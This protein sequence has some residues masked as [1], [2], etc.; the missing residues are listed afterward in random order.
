MGVAVGGWGAGG[1]AAVHVGDTGGA[2]PAPGKESMS[3]ENRSQ[4]PASQDWPSLRDHIADALWHRSRLDKSE[5]QAKVDACIR[6]LLGIPAAPPGAL[7]GVEGETERI[8]AESAFAAWV[9]R[10]KTAEAQVE[11]LEA[12]NRVPMPA[13]PNH[14]YWL[15]WAVRQMMVAC[16]GR[17]ADFKSVTEAAVGVGALVAKY[18]AHI[19]GPMGVK[20][21]EGAPTKKGGES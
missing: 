17:D 15:V 11:S 7:E 10:A 20:A 8:M 14:I 2:D 13:D 6:F 12:A 21:I 19:P 1:R 16:S 18:F 5:C 3:N 4:Q 9:T